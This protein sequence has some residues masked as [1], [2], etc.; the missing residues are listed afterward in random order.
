MLLSFF[1]KTKNLIFTNYNN[2]KQ[3]D[4]KKRVAENNKIK[5]YTDVLEL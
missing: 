2:L 5:K 4:Y 3:L 1:I